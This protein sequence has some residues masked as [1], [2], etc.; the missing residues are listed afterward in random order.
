MDVMCSTFSFKKIFF[1]EIPTGVWWCW[2]MVVRQVL[3]LHFLNLHFLKDLCS[4]AW[5]L[6][7]SHFSAVCEDAGHR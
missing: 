7:A 3:N 2:V 4:P 6:C 5:L 1:S